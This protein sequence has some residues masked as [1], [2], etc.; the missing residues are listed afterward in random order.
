MTAPRYE[1]LHAVRKIPDHPALAYEMLPGLI[2]CLS[3][4][5]M[6]YGTWICAWMRLL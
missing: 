3:Q 1:P 6:K 4:T 5:L 2:A